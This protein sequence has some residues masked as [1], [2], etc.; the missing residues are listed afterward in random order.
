M[1]RHAVDIMRKEEV[2]RSRER[3]W[4]AFLA[5]VAVKVPMVLVQIWL[6]AAHVEAPTA[7]AV[8]LAGILQK[9]ATYGFL[10]VSIRLLPR[11]S[12]ILLLNGQ[13]PPL[14]VSLHDPWCDL[15]G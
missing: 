10:R 3:F 4:I 12:R 8:V 14:H 15:H 5:V 9:L 7:G 1:L 11:A 13:G 6:P 2:K